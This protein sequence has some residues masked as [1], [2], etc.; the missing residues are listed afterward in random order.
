MLLQIQAHAMLGRTLL[1]SASPEC[2]SHSWNY[3]VPPSIPPPSQDS[4]KLRLVHL[5][6][7]CDGG[8][9]EGGL[10]ECC[11]QL[12]GT[13]VHVSPGI[14][15][16]SSRMEL[17]RRNPKKQTTILLGSCCTYRSKRTANGRAFP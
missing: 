9:I 4:V 13:R 15:C 3:K 14:L 10:L 11:L 5:D 12:L 2:F 16:H 7:L 6:L 17:Q 8:G 1:G